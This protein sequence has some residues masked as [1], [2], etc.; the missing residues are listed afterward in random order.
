MPT[1]MKD[2][3]NLKFDNFSSLTPL[4]TPINPRD[5]APQS[6]PGSLDAMDTGITPDSWRFTPLKTP[7][8]AKGMFNST[9]D[10]VDG[11]T[12]KQEYGVGSPLKQSEWAAMPNSEWTG[13]IDM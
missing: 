1:P 3:Q 4:R 9:A 13:M 8:F 5:F 2:L 11:H 10:M 12:L 6:T 7:G